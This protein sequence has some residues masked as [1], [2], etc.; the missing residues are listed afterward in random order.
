MGKA[1]VEMVHRYFALAVGVLIV[2]LMALAWRS[3]LRDR[4]RP[5]GLATVVFLWVCLQGAF[6]AWTVTQKLQP[7]FVTA[8]LLGGIALLALLVWLS[9]RES[10][11]PPDAHAA[12]LRGVGGLA[13]IVLF[14][15]DRAGWV[16]EFELCGHGLSRPT[17]VPGLLGA[18]GHGL[19][20]WIHPLAQ[21]G[22]T[23][24][25]DASPIPFQALV[26][27][28]WT[29]RTF[30]VV[31]LLTLA[32][33]A[34]CARA[35]PSTRRAGVWLAALLVLQMATGMSNV[36]F[37]WPLLL[38]VMHNGGAAALVAVVVTLNY[39]AGN[40][41]CIRSARSSRGLRQVPQGKLR[42]RQK[43]VS[44][45][46]P[47]FN[48]CKLRHI[49]PTPK[50]LPHL[51]R[52]FWSLTKPRVTQLALFCAVIGMFLSTP[53][54]PS[55]WLV[56]MATLGIWLLAG[57]AFAVNSI[58]ER[59]IDARMA[60][61]RARPLAR[62]EITPLQAIVFS[63][64]MGGAGMWVLYTQVNGLTMWLTFATF[65]GY[66]VIYTVLL[67]PHTPAEHRDW[68]H[69]RGD[70]AGTWMGGGDR[71]GTG[72]G[73]VAGVDHFCLDSAALLGARVV[74]AR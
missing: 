13:L 38:A 61:T 52:Q 51:A 65:V 44:S 73:M 23:G 16:G 68:R 14:V 69:E 4:S 49:E 6:G 17:A 3:W 19:C 21:S 9:L 5:A 25:A 10:R 64:L 74:S 36:I 26:A 30:A 34:W 8:H 7:A 33:L 62:G 29:H 67:K 41:K 54:L 48:A 22:M 32:R 28:H 43:L 60:R 72:P 40:H 18:S 58:I 71:D 63:G 56:A 66:A 20:E 45:P 55:L 50:R 31:A 59:H 53:E 70:A 47:A 37:E 35:G 42:R 57:A 12:S 1:W 15:A 2:V 39:R 27:I 11:S 24:G 46:S